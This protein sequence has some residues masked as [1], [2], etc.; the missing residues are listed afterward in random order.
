MT[1]FY[2]Q[3]WSTR[4]AAIQKIEEQLHNLD[5]RQRDAMYGEINRSNLPP[6]ITIKIFLQLITEGFKDP[7]LKNYLSLLELVQIALPTFFR[8]L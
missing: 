2:S 7:N 6:E 8:Y 3:T 5:P 1:C 4:A